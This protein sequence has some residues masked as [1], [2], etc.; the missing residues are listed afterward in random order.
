MEQKAK[1]HTGT[2]S[3]V[4]LRKQVFLRVLTEISHGNTE[5]NLLKRG[6][7]LVNTANHHD[8]RKILAYSLLARYF[9][10]LTSRNSSLHVSELV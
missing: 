8:S 5:G 7:P 2:N 10:T 1:G 9:V 4:N 6:K 3:D